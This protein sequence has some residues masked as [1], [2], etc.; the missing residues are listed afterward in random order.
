MMMLTFLPQIYRFDHNTLILQLKIYEVQNIALQTD[1]EEI[2][3][4]DS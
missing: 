4:Y 3:A 1:F 2:S